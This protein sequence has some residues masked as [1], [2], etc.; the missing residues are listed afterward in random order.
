MN[1]CI[2]YDDLDKQ[3]KYHLLQTID[4]IS[5]YYDLYLGNMI[6]IFTIDK[7]IPLKLILN[8]SDI[9]KYNNYFKFNLSEVL[10]VRATE[11]YFYIA[12][13]NGVSKIQHFYK[14]GNIFINEKDNNIIIYNEDNFYYL[15]GYGI[16]KKYVRRGDICYLIEINS[17]DNRVVINYKDNMI[18]SISNNIEI[19]YSNNYLSNI[20]RDNNTLISFLND[21]YIFSNK[22]IFLENRLIKSI[23]FDN[24]KYIY[25]YDNDIKYQ[26]RKIEKY[27][28][29][30]LVDSIF[31]N[32]YEDYTELIINNTSKKITFNSV[33]EL[34]DCDIIKI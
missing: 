34:D 33:G 29:N 7:N 3:I 21:T 15:E 16:R 24:Q 13:I 8:N 5:I 10:E 26:I 22:K 20:K 25:S 1:S 12:H 17:S 28:D 30:K 19:N 23:T 4:D 27:I 11:V 31:I 32:Y 18:S 14:N 9:H 6:S 2:A